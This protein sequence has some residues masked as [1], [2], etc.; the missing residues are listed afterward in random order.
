LIREFVSQFVIRNPM[1]VVLA[2]KF[3]FLKGGVERYLLDLEHLLRE[4]GHE[5]IPFAMRHPANL[6]TPYSKYFVS[7]VE[8]EKVKISWSGLRTL[9]RMFFSFEAQEKLSQLVRRFQPDLVH[10]H[11][12]YYQISPTI[13]LTLRELGVPIVMTV[14]DYHLLSPQYMRWSHHRVE[15]LS[16]VGIIQA[17]LSRFLKDSFLASLAAAAAFHLHER[18][19]LYHLADRYVVS[20]NFVKSEMIKKGFNPQKIHLL[21]FGIEGRRVTPAIGW[22]HGYVLYVGRLVEEKGIWTLLRAAKN[23]PQINFKIVG[24]GPEEAGLK[25][26]ASQLSNVEFVG[27]VAGEA[28]WN[29]YRGARSVVVPSLWQEVFGLVAL[30]A[31]AAGK[32]VIASNIGGLPEI[33]SDRVTGLLVQPGSVP[34]LTEAIERLFFDHGMTREMGFAGRERVL[35]DFTMEKHYEGLMEIYGEAIREHHGA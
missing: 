11:N 27:F 28:L 16:R 18:M 23:L 14:H 17:A 1:K 5:P 3:Y 30:E 33:V 7:R 13:F 35:K 9:G 8:T 29:L 22:D 6:P 12:I 4:H 2:N 10:V 26:A 31:M 34:E 21:P 19:G 20:T 15:D 24:T 25:K 32:P